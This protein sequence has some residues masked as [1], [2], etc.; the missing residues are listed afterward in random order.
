MNQTR[1][2]DPTELD[3]D[4]PD[5]SIPPLP[6][7]SAIPASVLECILGEIKGINAHIASETPPKWAMKLFDDLQKAVAQS[8]TLEG[9]FD[10]TIRRLQR[11]PCWES[12]RDIDC[13][14]EVVEG[15][16]RD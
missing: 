9:R 11:L 5:P 16:K 8:S 7:M 2:T 15:G 4:I 14:L 3:N 12:T 6:A 13:P 10:A 1:D